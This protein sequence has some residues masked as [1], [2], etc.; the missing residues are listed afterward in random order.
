ML[1]SDTIALMKSNDASDKLLAEYYQLKIRHAQLKSYLISWDSGELIEIPEIPRY[2]FDEQ[3]EAMEIYLRS[4]K[5]E[6]YFWV[7]IT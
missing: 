3:L 4:L 1:L 6:Y 7:S 5:N 2:I